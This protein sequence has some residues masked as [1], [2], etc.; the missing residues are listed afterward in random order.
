MAA[1]ATE[2]P[3]ISFAQKIRAIEGTDEV[4][5]AQLAV[6]ER[7]LARVTDGIYRRPSSAIRELIANAYDADATEVV[8]HTDA[9]RFDRIV[10]RD[11]G[12]GMSPENL[13]YLIHHIG[14][15]AKRTILG[16]GLNV[17]APEDPTKSPCGRKLIGKIGIGLFAVAQLTQHFQVI[18]KRKGD[19]YRTSADI[20]LRTHTENELS[21]SDGEVHFE[22]GSVAITREPASDVDWQGTEVILMDL[23]NNAKAILQSLDR[24]RVLEEAHEAGNLTLTP[25]AYH[26]GWVERTEPVNYK[27][28]PK[29]PWETSDPPDAKFRKLVDALSAEA[30]RTERSP[31]IETALDEYLSTLWILSLSVPVPYMERHPFHV[32]GR[33]GIRVYQL[34]EEARGQAKEV[35]LGLDETVAAKLGLKSAET[36][37][38]GGFNVFVDGI[39]LLRPVRLDNALRGNSAIGSPMLF[40]GSKDVL[41]DIPSERGGGALEFEA[42]IYWNSRIVPKENNG[43]LVQINRASGVLF[44]QRFMD[45]QVSELNRL[46]Q[47][48]S[49]L[50]VSDGLD[51]ALNIDRESFNYSHPHFQYVQKWLHKSIRQ[52]TNKLKGVN[53]E[54][55][56][57]KR[58]TA[59]AERLSNLSSYAQSVWTRKRPEEEEPVIKIVAKGGL[60]QTLFDARRKGDIILEEERIFANIRGNSVEKHSASEKTA[61]LV[62]VLEA[63]GLLENMS[64]DDQQSLVSDIMAIFLSE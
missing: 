24:W 5:R 44:D 26:I 25:P 42:Y 8:V 15:S 54:L 13:S 47:F 19:P 10:I 58:T 22:T 61:A 29:V 2:D 1:I 40:V 56:D 48:M 17:T 36:D 12:R 34:S 50:Y 41:R 57:R 37:P 3:S 4:C 14:G 63:Y 28:P 51:A 30:E 32:T 21:Q 60:Q 45:Y 64:Y 27:T 55:L 23:R 6:D 38:L 59:E 39:Q 18:T 46:R 52:A 33:D 20:V 49:E 31:N 62:K 53:K 11:N 9:P 7:V 16:K 35:V 43:V